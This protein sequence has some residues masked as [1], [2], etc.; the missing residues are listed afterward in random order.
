MPSETLLHFGPFSLDR[1]AG[2]LRA[3]ERRLDLDAG[4][5]AVLAALVT[6][7]GK[8]LQTAE[9]A[10]CL[11]SLTPAA[12][13]DEDA[14]MASVE[15]INAALATVEPSRFY[16]AHFPGQGFVFASAPAAAAAPGRLPTRLTPVLGREPLIRR[17]AA[18]VQT[19]RLVTVVGPG[20]MGKTTV[21]VAL[22]ARLVERF[23][24]GV[25]F[26]DLAPVP[27]PRHLAGALAAALGIGATSVES[28]EALR[29]YFDGRRLLFVL[30][31]CE[32]LVDA[33][34][35]LVEQL[36]AASI[37]IHVL[38]TSREPLQ[39]AG[40]WLQRLAP[41]G[42]PA[43]AGTLSARHAM[44]CAA[45]Q[46]FVQR[47]RA[48]LPDFAL[49]DTLAPVVASICWRLDGIPLAIE[50][51]A[52][53]LPLLGVHGLAQQLESRLLSLAGGRRTAPQRH[54][55]LVALLDWSYDLLSADEQAV[56]RRLSVFHGAF[57][58]DLAIAV[59]ADDDIT[60]AHAG[61][62]VLDLIAK[63]L[64]AK[65]AEPGAPALRL[66]D[67][68]RAYAAQRLE[69]GPE[70][71]ALRRRHAVQLCALLQGAEASWE[72]LS[73][74]QWRAVYAPW[75][76]DVRAALDWAFSKAGDAQ[77]GIEMTVAS[78]ALADQ[79]ALMSDYIDH[80]YRALAALAQMPQPNPLLEMQLSTFPAIGLQRTQDQEPQ[81]VA[82]LTRA[83][84]IGRSTGQ[85][86]RQVGPLLGLW[87]YPFQIGN[88]PDT[89][90]WT[91][92]LRALA[93][94]HGDRIADLT[95]R[96]TMAQ[97]LHFLGEHTS[98][99]LLAHEVLD[100]GATKI[101]LVY[102]PSPVSVAVSMRILLA[103][104][105][106]I[107]GFPAQAAEM[108]AAGV[109]EAEADPPVSLCQALALAALPIAVWSGDTEVCA[110]GVA[111][112]RRQVTVYSFRYWQAWCTLY[113]TVL[114]CGKS[115]DSGDSGDIG[116]ALARLP[117]DGASHTKHRDHIATFGA[118]VLGDDSLARVEGGL[119]GWCAPEVLRVEAE[120]L[121]ARLEPADQAR[122]RA[123]LARALDLARAQ[124]ALSWELRIACSMVRVHRREP[125][126]QRAFDALASAYG[127]FDEG[128]GTADL[129]AAAALLAER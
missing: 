17:L 24:D 68:T 118:G 54:Q 3:G 36:L 73:R 70:Q 48:A 114:A 60:P 81:Y 126:A 97:S 62:C 69:H 59:V 53:R 93:D 46:L 82:K 115:A 77:L 123:L 42:L 23:A 47:A 41:M 91:Q 84:E 43:R 19:H 11:T 8:A 50:L 124:G 63:S 108:A 34:A 74:E 18:Q 25:C 29:A 5:V 26:V 40:E 104:S 78:F 44:T 39:L 12:Q 79:T 45:V 37:G 127:R 67:T 14:V 117:M 119:V 31:S 112:L 128:L 4:A 116:A 58:F 30:D 21:A 16:A 110:A 83:L 76:D 113:E 111:R 13:R 106:W 7:A 107:R 89:L 64:V 102:K 20:G 38:A 52:A 94:R 15:R 22:A 121:S 88:Y 10:T 75:I 85:A 92:Q 120:R 103:R 27:Q 9:L 33:V 96:R 55:T 49:D 95:A 61:G 109:A 100:R 2:E 1:A 6:Q 129:R 56:L 72:R 71:D 51:A 28:A 87:A 99:T 105:L 86:A 35:A 57:T 80:A 90:Q 98:A 125:G 65:S 122:G 101:P 66:L 32:R